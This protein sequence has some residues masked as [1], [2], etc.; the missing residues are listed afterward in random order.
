M[1]CD[2]RACVFHTTMCRY[3]SYVALLRQAYK[4]KKPCDFERLLFSNPA[5]FVSEYEFSTKVFNVE[6]RASR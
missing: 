6:S 1:V 3:H 5:D 2:K 4:S